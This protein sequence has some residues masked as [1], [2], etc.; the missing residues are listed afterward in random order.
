MVQAVGILGLSLDKQLEWIEAATSTSNIDY[1]EIRTLVTS[2]PQSAR[3]IL[4]TST[5]RDFFVGVCDNSTIITAVTDLHYDLQTQLE[6][7][8]EEASP[9]KIEYSQIQPLVTG[10]PQ[11]DRDALKTTKWRDFFV[12]VCNNSTIVTAVT[13]LHY[14]LQTQLEWIEE[15]ASASNIEYS[16]IQSLVTG[17]PQAQRDALKTN[18]WRDFFVGVCTKTTIITAITDLHFDTPTQ[19]AWVNEEGVEFVAKL[20]WLITIG[21]DYDLIRP[22]ILNASKS[23][24][25]NALNDTALQTLINSKLAAPYTVAVFSHLL[26]DSMYWKGKTRPIM[27]FLPTL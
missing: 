15:E 4:K 1:S 23:D 22:E 24:R 12:G 14:D 26:L 19:L 7:I 5:W 11:A 25:R 2:A 17:A 3:D 8:E 21:G 6:W 13:D 10:A 27:N 20:T 16:Q 9:S 18:K